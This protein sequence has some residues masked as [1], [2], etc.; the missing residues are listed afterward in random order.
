M[1][2]SRSRHTHDLSL[3]PRTVLRS[4]TTTWLHLT[5]R[6]QPLPDAAAASSRSSSR[7]RR[8]IES[9]RATSS[10]TPVAYF[11]LQVPHHES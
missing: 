11:T 10:A 6:V 8:R 2:L 9:E 5:P 1:N 4:S 7:R 3:P